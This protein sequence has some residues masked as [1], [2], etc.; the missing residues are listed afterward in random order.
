MS[1][2]TEGTKTG[3]NRDERSPKNA[4]IERTTSAVLDAMIELLV[5]VGYR[6]ITVEKIS[7]S[8]GVA[9]STIYRHWNNVP[10]LAIEAFDAA[11]GPAPKTPDLGDV[12]TNLIFH[13]KRFAK[14]LRS[15]VRGKLMPSLLEAAHNIP[16]FDVLFE[17]LVHKRSESTREILYRAIDRGEVHPDT[18]VEW[19]ID[20]LA[21][22]FHHRL[23]ITGGKL[24]EHGMVE[25]IV[26]SSLSQVSAPSADTRTDQKS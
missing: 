9:R 18:K 6:N 5:T 20:L 24:S 22:L 3:M 15:G 25:W 16:G 21:G 23:L 11:L 10:E 1:S 19:V 13:Y 4:Q 14:M 8:S 7:E 12:R 17:D 26:D 2:A